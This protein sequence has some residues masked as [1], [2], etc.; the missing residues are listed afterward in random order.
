MTTLKSASTD[1][2]ITVVTGAY[3]FRMDS[4][5][6]TRTS[7][8]S[9]S[10]PVMAETTNPV[11]REVAD[12]DNDLSTISVTALNTIGVSFGGAPQWIAPGKGFHRPELVDGRPLRWTDGDGDLAIPIEGD[13]KPRQLTISIADTGPDGGPLRITLNDVTLFDAVV[14]AGPW[15][16][17]FDVSTFGLDRG[18]MADI[19]IISDTFEG[20]PVDETDR[21]T[22]FGVQVDQVK[23]LGD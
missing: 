14:P 8:V 20:T 17:E 10:S 22:E 6:G 7:E 1:H 5:V 19:D 18:D 23:L 16:G 9:W 13:Q 12:Q 3:D 15:S 2:P 11:P 4:L 21:E